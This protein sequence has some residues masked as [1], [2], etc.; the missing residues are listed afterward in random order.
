MAY[1][2][3]DYT[4][5]NVCVDENLTTDASGLLRIQPYAVPRRVVFAKG[6]SGADGT[7]F[8]EI[9]LPGKMLIEIRTRWMNDTPMPQQMMIRVV[10]SSK[11]WITSNPN[12]I[13]FRDRWTWT[14]DRDNLTPNIPVT[15]GVY[16]SQCGS[17]ADMGTN[18]VAEPLPGRHWMWTDAV[19]SDEWVGET[20]PGEW[21]NVW[22]RQYVWT[23]PP[24]SDNANKN[25]PLH[26]AYAYWAAIELWAYPTRSNLVNG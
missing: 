4:E 26:E 25:N 13:Q 19:T 11:K 23:P 24:W 14:I 10:R 18:T 9:A 22:Y 15:T 21:L 5:P 3:L 7:L 16:N 20:Q 12:A 2:P 17:A 1:S 8:P 6:T